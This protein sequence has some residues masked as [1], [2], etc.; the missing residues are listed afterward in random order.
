MKLKSNKNIRTIS[1]IESFTGGLFSYTITKESGASKYFHG[2]IITYHNKVK[3][4]LKIDTSNGVINKDIA[5]AMA[6]AGQRIFNT[7]ICVSFTGVAGPKTLENKPIG[8]IFIAINEE[9]YSLNL[10]GNRNS[11]KK[12]A[13][14]FAIEKINNL[15]H[16]YTK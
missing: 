2:S 12:Q 9:V 8:T 14:L 7:D 3:E 15:F 5:L 6:K 1:A 11:I 16:S 10:K 13:V 4:M